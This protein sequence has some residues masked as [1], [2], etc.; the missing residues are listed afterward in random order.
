LHVFAAC[1]DDS[2]A[3]V[4]TEKELQ[5]SP[6]SGNTVWTVVLPDVGGVKPTDYD[7]MQI[8]INGGGPITPVTVTVVNPDSG[9][10][11]VCWCLM[12]QLWFCRLGD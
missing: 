5:P 2:K 11:P 8:V 1:P 4:L 10:S 3:S 7:I 9:Y 12:N 6:G